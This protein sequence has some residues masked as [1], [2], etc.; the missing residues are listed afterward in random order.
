MKSLA[1]QENT[2]PSRSGLVSSKKCLFFI[3]L[4]AFVLLVALSLVLRSLF[5]REQLHQP[6]PELKPEKA[7]VLTEEIK[8][9]NQQVAQA[10]GEQKEQKVAEMVKVA[11]ERKQELEK[12]LV[13]NPAEFI[14]LATLASERKTLPE[15]VQNII[16]EEVSVTGTFERIHI[17]NFQHPSLEYRLRDSASDQTYQLHI[18]KNQPSLRSGSTVKV[19]GLRLG[20]RMALA[21]GGGS[22][23]QAA[24]GSAELATASE[25]VT[26][27]KVATI[28]VKF[29]NEPAEPFSADSVRAN[30]LGEPATSSAKPFLKEASYNQMTLTGDV[31]GWFTLPINSPDPNNE[32]GCHYYTWETKAL[33]IAEAN[34][35]VLANYDR[36][37]VIWNK[38]VTQCTFAGVAGSGRIVIN[39]LSDASL[40]THELGHTFGLSHASSIACGAKVI[41]VFPK[42]TTSEYGDYYDTMGGSYYLSLPH[43]QAAFKERIGWL[44]QTQVKEVTTSGTYTVAPFEIPNDAVQALKIKRSDGNGYYYLE[45]RQPLGFDKTLPIEATKGVLIHWSRSEGYGNK[46]LLDPKPADYVREA[47]E[48]GTAFYDQLNNITIS[49]VSHN[50]S[51][52]TVSI[53]LGPPPSYTSMSYFSDINF[54]SYG[55]STEI[56]KSY[57]TEFPA[58]GNTLTLAGKTYTKGVGT[59]APSTLYFSTEGYCSRLTADVGVDDEVGSQGRINFRVMGDDQTLY[60]SGIMTGD[61]PTKQVDVDIRGYRTVYLLTEELGEF[62]AYNHGDWADAKIYCADGAVPPQGT[63]TINDNIPSYCDL[64]DN[65]PVLLLGW[66]AITKAWLYRIDY[67]NRSGSSTDSGYFTTADTY[68]RITTLQP[69]ATYDFTVTAL[70]INGVVVATSAPKTVKHKTCAPLSATATPKLTPSVAVT[71]TPTLRHNPGDLNGDKLINQADYD[72][73]MIGFKQTESSQLDLNNDGRVDIYDYNLLLTNFGKNV[74]DIPDPG[75]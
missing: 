68:Y 17:D 67:T 74:D 49:Q 62:S 19:S 20:G 38:Y 70:D 18:V 21:F 73:F 40:F 46:F 45:Y 24:T 37:M 35:V 57:N 53:T 50:A 3:V 42:C 61:S 64:Y 43:Y 59:A 12:K 52:A 28:M 66:N 22:S 10:E 55:K 1:A 16:E 32:Y 5:P 23:F 63:I 36:T 8:V 54:A 58:D 25:P 9:I 47:L 27:A 71:V 51:A 2:P 11:T 44:T 65:T 72:L 33:E 56:D 48:D 14:Q 26:S 34:G 15:E 7:K 4:A 30:L 60:D 41:D 69:G 31:F 6:L 29:Q 13:K 75:F 39:G